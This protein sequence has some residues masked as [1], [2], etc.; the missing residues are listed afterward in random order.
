[1]GRLF[2]REVDG[3][4]SQRWY[5]NLTGVRG[6]SDSTA[7]RHFNVFHHMMEKASGPR[8]PASTG[9]RQT[10]GHERHQPDKSF[11]ARALDGV[12]CAGRTGSEC[13][14]AEDARGRCATHAPATIRWSVPYPI[15]LHNHFVKEAWLTRLPRP[16]GNAYELATPAGE[17]SSERGS[18]LPPH[19]HPAECSLMPV[20]MERTST[21]PRGLLR[22]GSSG[23]W[24]GKRVDD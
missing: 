4:V 20:W 22:S 23:T 1:M 6:L 18:M 10:A 7:V 21:A 13:I 12:E 15:L 19:L 5:E 16:R 2:V 24:T 9:I 11:V 3:V 8:K 14:R 17:N